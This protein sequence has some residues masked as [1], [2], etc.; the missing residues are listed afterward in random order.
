MTT[1]APTP[2]SPPRARRKPPVLFKVILLAFVLVF[3]LVFAEI[4][5]RVAVKARGK[6]LSVGPMQTQPDDYYGHWL[7]PNVH[8]TVTN[9]NGIRYR[10]RTNSHGHRGPEY[11]APPNG[12]I[13]CLGDSYT[14]GETVDAGTEYAALLRDA[15][16]PAGYEVVNFA[17]AGNGQ[18]RWLKFLSRDLADY[19]P[20]LVVMQ[21]CYNDFGDNEV[22]NLYRRKDDGTL[23]SLPVPGPG[24]VDRI[25]DI[26]ESIPGVPYLYTYQVIKQS[27]RGTT[28]AQQG[29]H[30]DRE[31]LSPEHR[32]AQDALLLALVRASLE[33]CAA[34]GAP[35][36]WTSVGLPQ[37]RHD[38]IAALAAEFHAIELPM[39]YSDARP[40]LYHDV[41]VDPHWNEAGHRFV[42]DGILETIRARDLLSPEP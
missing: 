6:P 25:R 12:H 27:I 17:R 9:S 20:R 35:V 38:A 19:T 16:R 32:A 23:E 15:L 2:P 1:P 3:G 41:R 39:P 42:A 37:D 34:A 21:F 26:V 31:E 14:M 11:I 40:D 13:I 4:A 18:G 8:T 29:F 7:R 36:I 28:R 30:P 22:E 24:A 10:E 33:K 5:V